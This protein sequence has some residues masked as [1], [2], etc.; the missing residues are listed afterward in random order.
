MTDFHQ[1]T[2]GFLEVEAREVARAAGVEAVSSAGVTGS[3]VIIRR[4]NFDITPDELA[5]IVRLDAETAAE[6]ERDYLPKDVAVTDGA[7]T[8]TPDHLPKVWNDA[9]ELRKSRQGTSNF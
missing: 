8:V 9:K 4:N 6:V 1:E 2:Q 3:P 5:R 7:V